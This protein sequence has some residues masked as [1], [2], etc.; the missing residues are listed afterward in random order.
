MSPCL[1]GQ[2]GLTCGVNNHRLPFFRRQFL[3]DDFD[4][5]LRA[6]L[7]PLLDLLP[8]D[9]Y[10]KLRSLSREGA[11]PLGLDEIFPWCI[12]L[13]TVEMPTVVSRNSPL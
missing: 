3:S 7:F 10:V 2:Q 11:M 9:G 1:R 4:L 5:C 8:L 13:K 12:P 6:L